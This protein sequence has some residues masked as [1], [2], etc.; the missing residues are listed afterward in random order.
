MGTN[1]PTSLQ[2]PNRNPSWARDE[3]ILALDYFFK[4]RNRSPQVYH[5]GIIRLS[6]LL[7][8]LPINRERKNNIAFRS[9][10]SVKMKLNNFLRFDP[11]Y[12]GRALAAGSKLEKDLWE[13][14][15]N[16]QNRLDILAQRIV[17]VS[18]DK[19]LRY[20]LEPLTLD[21]N[22][23]EAEEGQVIMKLH[24][25]RER[26]PKLVREKIRKMLQLKGALSCEICDFDFHKTYGETGEGFIEC[27]HAIPLHDLDSSR[28]TKISDLLLVCSNCHRM[29]HRGELVPEMLKK[30]MDANRK[31]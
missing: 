22:E 12:G 7:N 27:H 3:L 17:K 23:M 29:L 2:M 16:D 28:L 18:N 26:N 11:S 30:Q 1:M 6:E 31:I 4:N 21:E 5:L 19:S 10:S 14:F 25:Y 8:A 13:E 20:E 15:V 9:P 24:K